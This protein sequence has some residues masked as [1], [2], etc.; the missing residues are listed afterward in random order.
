VV[1]V[2]AS[3]GPVR[4]FSAF[5]NDHFLHGRP[6]VASVG[7]Y[8]HRARFYEARTSTFLEPDPLGPVDSPNLYAAFGFDA[9]SVTDPW[10][11]ASDYNFSVFDSAG[12]VTKPLI[13][14]KRIPLFKPVELPKLPWVEFWYNLPE[15]GYVGQTVTGCLVDARGRLLPLAQQARL[16]QQHPFLQVPDNPGLAQLIRSP[17]LVKYSEQELLKIYGQWVLLDL[18]VVQIGGFATATVAGGLGLGE[19]AGTAYAMGDFASKVLLA[20]S[21]ATH[22]IQLELKGLA[23]DFAS[24]Y[25]GRSLE[26]AIRSISELTQYE[27]YIL[28]S[29]T[30]LF[31][32]FFG[33][34]LADTVLNQVFTKKEKKPDLKGR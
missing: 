26:K 21:A 11:L 16:L 28:L 1:W 12:K 23:S 4:A 8:D 29:Q 9:L 31:A 14:V 34:S 24:Y 5:G 22:T 20:Q 19:L 15:V 7:L 17:Q 27:R 25:M 13:R 32:D 2:E 3:Q 6:Y 18:T 30:N 10:G 33:E